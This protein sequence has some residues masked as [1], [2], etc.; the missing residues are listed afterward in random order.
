MWQN[1]RVSVAAVGW[2]NAAGRECVCVFREAAAAEQGVVG[3]S[4]QG[5][6]SASSEAGRCATAW[7]GRPPPRQSH[8]PKVAV[9]HGAPSPTVYVTVPVKGIM[10]W[11]L[12]FVFGGGAVRAVGLELDLTSF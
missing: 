2:H 9:T 4:H 11:H 12:T 7:L 3:D 10:A 5:Q 1:S 8:F 6:C